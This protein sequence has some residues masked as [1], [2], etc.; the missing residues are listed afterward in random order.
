MGWT[1]ATHKF[2]LGLHVLENNSEPSANRNSAARPGRSAASATGS[3]DERYNEAFERWLGRVGATLKGRFDRRRLIEL[4]HL[5]IDL[6]MQLDSD[7]IRYAWTEWD[8]RNAHYKGPQM[9]VDVATNDRPD[10][11]RQPPAFVCLERHPPTRRRRVGGC[12]PPNGTYE[13]GGSL[14]WSG[15]SFVATSTSI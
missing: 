7:E 8:F 13:A 6:G 5:L 12:A 9:D 10:Q 4:H 15:R 11:P 1:F 2:G 14:G 3:F